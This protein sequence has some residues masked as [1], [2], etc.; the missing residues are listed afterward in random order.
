M[1]SLPELCEIT[2]M[3]ILWGVGRD[4]IYLFI[5]IISKLAFF[6]QLTCNGVIF[7]QQYLYIHSS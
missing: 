4:V 6:F 3:L 1:H 5:I 2:A 7:Y